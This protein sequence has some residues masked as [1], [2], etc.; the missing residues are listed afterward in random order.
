MASCT[1]KKV[2]DNLNLIC[3]FK[4]IIFRINTGLAIWKGYGQA[5]WPKIFFL[6]WLR[7]LSKGIK[8]ALVILYLNEHEL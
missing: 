5:F 4:S 6:F 3:I 7:F 1:G 8:I 2:K